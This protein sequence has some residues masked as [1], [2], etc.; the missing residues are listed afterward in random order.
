MTSGR[1]PLG[2]QALQ[3]TPIFGFNSFDIG[4]LKPALYSIEFKSKKRSVSP[5]KA[6]RV[7]FEPQQ[8]QP[9]R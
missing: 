1:K 4:H 7:T 9:L 3:L 2:I 5:V 8:T 6:S